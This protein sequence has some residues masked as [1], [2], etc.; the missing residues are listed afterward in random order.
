VLTRSG[1]V[2][3]AAPRV[4]DKRVNEDWATPAVL[5]GDLARL[6]PQVAED[7]RGLPFLYLHGLSSPDSCPHCSSSSA[8]VTAFPHR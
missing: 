8:P 1:A 5:L 3:V 7:Q 2:E 4:N 6:V